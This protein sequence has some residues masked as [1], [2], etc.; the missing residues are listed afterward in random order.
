MITHRFAV[1][2]YVPAFE[3][4]LSGRSGKVVLDWTG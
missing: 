3:A 2:D 1:D 4:M